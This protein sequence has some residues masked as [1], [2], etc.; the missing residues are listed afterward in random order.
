MSEGRVHDVYERL[1]AIVVGFEIR[2]GDRLNEGDLARR[3]AVSRTPLREA[4]NRLAAERLVE[5]RPGAGFFCR[6]LDADGVFDTYE[7][8]LALETA[9]VRLACARGAPEAIAALRAELEAT[10]LETRG[11]TVGEAVARDEAFHLGV[12]RLAR[13]PEIATEL[14]RVNERIRFIRWVDMAARVATTK[15]EHRAIM[16]AIEARDEAAAVAVMTAH[17]ARRMDQVVEAVRE[18]YS[19]IYVNG[20]AALAER[21][22]ERGEPR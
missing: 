2:P 11:L 10:G 12:A 3:L 8:R 20:P 14:G 4:L 19:N 1:K 13:A 5:I 7:L 9:A 17:I 21:V 6:A 22:L 18:G 16:A 15:G